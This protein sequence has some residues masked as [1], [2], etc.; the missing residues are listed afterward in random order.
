MDGV[1]LL[2]ASG[3]RTHLNA[4]ARWAVARCGPDRIGSFFIFESLIRPAIQTHGV[5][6]FHHWRFEPISYKN[7]RNFMHIKE[8]SD[9]QN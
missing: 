1:F 8:Q 3:I 4:T 7:R 6:C 5:F 2:A 9:G